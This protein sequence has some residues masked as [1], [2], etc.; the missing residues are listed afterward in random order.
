MTPEELLDEEELANS[1]IRNEQSFRFKRGAIFAGIALLLVVVG[2]LFFIRRGDI[3]FGDIFNGIAPSMLGVILPI[4]L[5]WFFGI[6]SGAISFSY[7]SKPSEIEVDRRIALQDI[8]QTIISKGVP[9]RE[10]KRM[11]KSRRRTQG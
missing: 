2:Y 10:I 4:L 8:E 1:V 9:R 7:F 11:R 3:G 5:P 6:C